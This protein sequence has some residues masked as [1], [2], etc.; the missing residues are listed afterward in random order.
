MEVK[1]SLE[2]LVAIE[3]IGIAVAKIVKDGKVN[4]EDLPAALELLN[5][6]AKLID[7]FKG[8]KEIPVE[9]KELSNEELLVLGAKG[10]DMVK[11]II[12]AAKA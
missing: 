11:N 10:Y 7:G 2:L 9:F 1:E 8:V 5:N 3:I 6:F 4:V 12:G